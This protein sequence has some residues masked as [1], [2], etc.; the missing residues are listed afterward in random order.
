MSNHDDWVDRE[1]FAVRRLQYPFACF[2]CRKSFKR[3]VPELTATDHLTCPQCSGQAVR[4]SRNFKP[5]PAHRIDQW[6]KVKA[7]VDAGFLF[8]HVQGPRGYEP[9]PEKLRDVADFVRRFPRP[10]RKT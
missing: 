2:T 1:K 7:L 4:L 8:E 6:A 9:Y 5:P 10:T 3:R